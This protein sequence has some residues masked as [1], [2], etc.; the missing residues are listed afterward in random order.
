MINNT[1]LIAISHL[2]KI[3]QL[4]Y[5]S[6]L[7]A[8]SSRSPELRLLYWPGCSYSLSGHPEVHDSML[9][10]CSFPLVGSFR[11][12]AETITISSS[13]MSES[14]FICLWSGSFSHYY[15]SI[16]FIY[17][18]LTCSSLSLDYQSRCFFSSIITSSST[19][20]F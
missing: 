19:S 18:V 15:C 14:W 8:S 12:Y 11:S 10:I 20:S 7:L 9:I 4:Y 3:I 1:Y 2:N 6:Q 5:K 13:F 17:L 16:T